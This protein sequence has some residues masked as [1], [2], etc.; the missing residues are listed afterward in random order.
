MSL[1]DPKNINYAIVN[2]QMASS[3]FSN[4]YVKAELG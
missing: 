4:L 2:T 1:S 3:E